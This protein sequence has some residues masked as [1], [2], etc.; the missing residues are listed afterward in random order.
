[1]KFKDFRQQLNERR[2]DSRAVRELL[3][4]RAKPYEYW[5]S[6]KFTL[7]FCISKPMMTRMQ[8]TETEIEAFH[9]TDIDYIG[10]LFEVQNSSKSLSVTTKVE[11]VR[12]GVVMMEGVE[13]G[14]GILVELVGDVPFAGDSDIFTSPDSQ[15]RRWLDIYQFAGQL[16]KRKE[17]LAN[18][19][20]L[21]NWELIYKK[22]ILEHTKAFIK[23]NWHELLDFGLDGDH[24]GYAVRSKEWAAIFWIGGEGFKIKGL[25]SIF[26]LAEKG[27]VDKLER[28]PDGRGLVRKAKQALFKMTKDLFD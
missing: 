6:R 23:T 8:N 22:T 4:S 12:D 13:T 10:T 27:V 25:G 28:H 20:L 21:H 15:G 24:M 7:P 5:L 14:G 3:S 19:D 18:P 17:Y 11:S 9:V 1:M 16:S 2:K 26:S